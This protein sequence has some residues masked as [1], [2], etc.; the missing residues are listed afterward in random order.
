[1]RCKRT[2]DISLVKVQDQATT[3]FFPS[4]SPLSKNK[5]IQL[6]QGMSSVLKFDMEKRRNADNLLPGQIISTFQQLAI[7]GDLSPAGAAVYLKLVGKCLRTNIWHISVPIVELSKE[8]GLAVNT[9]QK[10]LTELVDHGILNK[11]RSSNN[12]E[13]LQYSWIHASAAPAQQL[14]GKLEPD[15][16]PFKNIIEVLLFLSGDPVPLDRL[17]R[18]TED[19]AQNIINAIA[20]LKAD[21]NDKPLMVADIATGYSI[22]SRPEYAQYAKIVASKKEPDLSQTEREVLSIIMLYQRRPVSREE[23]G[24]L[25]GAMPTASLESLIKKH[26]VEELETEDPPAL[27]QPTKEAFAHFGYKGYEDVPPLNL[28]TPQTCQNV[29][30]NCHLAKD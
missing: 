11:F 28:L 2:P 9:V 17:T 4:L 29:D 8:F 19:S 25:R 12:K 23:I 26:W 13:P 5:I 10:G 16:L 3:L 6:D 14:G 27:F 15:V 30:Q 24:K 21:Y 22:V 18:M 1:M 20:E 7:S